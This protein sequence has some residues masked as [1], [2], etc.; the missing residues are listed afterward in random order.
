MNQIL[1]EISNIG[2][3]PVVACR[4]KDRVQVQD[5]DAERGEIRQLFLN[6]PERSAPERPRSA[7]PASAPQGRSRRE[8]R[9]IFA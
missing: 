8:E 2:V 6:A 7:A 1:E 3:V 4:L 9:L 5:R